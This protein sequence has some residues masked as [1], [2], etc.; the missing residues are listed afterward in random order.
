M[1]NLNLT[2]IFV[3]MVLL[4]FFVS[5]SNVSA[6]NITVDNGMSSDFI[7][8][9]LDNTMGILALHF[10]GSGGGVFDDISL[11]IDKAIIITC[12]PG[13]VLRGGV[14]EDFSESA[15]SIFADGVSV[16]G[17]TISGYFTGI[18]A[19]SVNNINIIGNVF[20]DN[21]DGISIVDSLGVVISGNTIRGDGDFGFGVSIVDSSNVGVVGNNIDNVGSGVVV[22]GSNNTD[23]SGNNISGSTIAYY[24][25]YFKTFIYYFL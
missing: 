21:A 1:F 4:L 9:L 13:V 10:S 19:E 6:S 3:A 14:L 5:L 8:E 16:S 24:L 18:V 22:S 25:T 15:F 7:Q 11:I 2:K 12:D 23:V 20:L 17:F